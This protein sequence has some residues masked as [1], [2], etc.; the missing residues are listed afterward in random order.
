M[1]YNYSSNSDLY[2]IIMKLFQPVEM[3]DSCS[4][5]EELPEIFKTMQFAKNISK[6]HCVSFPLTKWHQLD[7]TTFISIKVLVDLDNYENYIL[8]V[9]EGT[10]WKGTNTIFDTDYCIDIKTDIDS[11]KQAIVDIINKKIPLFNKTKNI[12]LS[13]YPYLIQDQ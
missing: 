3:H 7:E 9:I 5:V 11:V 10:V 2:P 4:A 8:R 6:H 12:D 13:R 1:H